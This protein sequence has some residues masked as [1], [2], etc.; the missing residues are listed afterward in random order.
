MAD[1]NQKFINEGYIKKILSSLYDWMPFKKYN[2]GTIQNNTNKVT[3][4]G[5]IALGSYNESDIDTLLS[6]GIG[7]D[8]IR[9]N[10]IKINNNGE[11]YIITDLKTNSIESLQNSLNKKG[12]TI[13]ESYE[14]MLPF[15]STEYLGKLLW[16]NNQYVYND[17]TWKRGLYIVCIDTQNDGKLGLFNLGSSIEEELANYYTKEEVNLLLDKA[18]AGDLDLSNYYTIS[19]IDTKIEVL[20]NRLDNI[21]EWMNNPIEIED[22]ERITN[23]DLNNDGI[24]NTLK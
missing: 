7:S 16:L 12:V 19:E 8:G 20:N 22:L 23:I 14:E 2:E 3:N 15:L 24:I 6:I 5:E 17:N 4:S 11:I 9:K 21:E 10:A 1:N 18:I 13:C